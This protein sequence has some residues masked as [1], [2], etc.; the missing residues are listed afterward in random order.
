M[1]DRAGFSVLDVC[2]AGSVVA[3]VLAVLVPGLA[4]ARGDAN[5]AKCEANLHAIGTALATYA[6]RNSDLM[7]QVRPFNLPEWTFGPK[8]SPVLLSWNEALVIDGSLKQEMFREGDLPLR[9]GHYPAAGFGVFVCPSAARIHHNGGGMA[10]TDLGYGL[11]WCAASDFG[12]KAPGRIA[13]GPVLVRTANLVPEHIIMAE[14]W[15]L[16]AISS[17]NN[18]P[19]RNQ[20]G[21]YERHQ[22]DGVPGANYLFADYH[23]E[24]SDAY[25][26]VASPAYHGARTRKPIVP[27]VWVHP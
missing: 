26:H 15:T 9:S 10:P 4:R 17:S 20:Y 5:L 19:N 25:A 14:G 21:V 11:G 13:P 8:K 1:K 16:M 27:P 7:P 24:W 23:V 18:H 2:A 22:L 6:N 3:I 12:D